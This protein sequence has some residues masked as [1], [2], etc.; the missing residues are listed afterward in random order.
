MLMSCRKLLPNNSTKRAAGD[1]DG[2]TGDDARQ[3]GPARRGL[4]LLQDARPLV[5]I[6]FN[7]D[8][9]SR[10]FMALLLAY[11]LIDPPQAFAIAEPIIDR[12]ND[13]ISKLLLLD[14]IVRSGAVKS[15]EIV[16]QD[17]GVPLDFRAHQVRTRVWWRWRTPISTGQER[18]PTAFR[19]MN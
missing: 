10:A 1:R 17:P 7:S 4:K 6:D 14:K 3:K 19:E 13:N 11:A 16:M 18:S 2:G 15:G 8:T 12:A 9:Q 5:K